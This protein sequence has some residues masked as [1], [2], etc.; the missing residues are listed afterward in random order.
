MQMFCPGC[1]SEND[2]EKKY[3]RQCGKPLSA[4]RV[5]LDG[6][7]DEAIKVVKGEEGNFRYRLRIALAVFLI[8]VSIATIFS[9]GWLG[10]SNLQSAAVIL[11]I[12]LLL[13]LQSARKSHRVAR[14]LNTQT[15]AVDLGLSQTDAGSPLNPSPSAASVATSDASVTEQDTFRL[16]R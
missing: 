16:H 6:R 2:A 12:I 9:G 11:I 15:Q 3:C 10:F 13:F 8:L 4:V 5:A 1:G 14:L 7:I